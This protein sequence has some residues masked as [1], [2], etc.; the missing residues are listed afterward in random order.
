MLRSTLP[1]R[2]VQRAVTVIWDT[3]AFIDQLVECEINF[4]RNFCIDMIDQ[5][6]C[7][8]ELKITNT[9][10]IGV[11]FNEINF[12]AFFVGAVANQDVAVQDLWYF[13]SRLASNILGTCKLPV[14]HHQ[15]ISSANFY[16]AGLQF[17]KLARPHTIAKN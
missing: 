1:D 10:K 17:A 11:S 6:K 16:Q 14:S 5:N 4:A 2:P 9:H 13:I 12:K 8:H 3:G 7:K 15:S